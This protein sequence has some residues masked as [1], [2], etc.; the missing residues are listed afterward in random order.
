MARVGFVCNYGCYICAPTG[1]CSAV[2]K[3]E[4]FRRYRKGM[5][6]YR[7]RRTSV[8]PG[9]DI[10]AATR[11]LLARARRGLVAACVAAHLVLAPGVLPGVGA[12]VAPTGPV[13]ALASVEPIG[14]A[15]APPHGGFRGAR[16]ATGA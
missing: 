10:L 7:G 4:L 16:P 2:V 11:K 1:K 6:C 9:S 8:E 3:R 13:H 15:R 14:S 12:V 5:L